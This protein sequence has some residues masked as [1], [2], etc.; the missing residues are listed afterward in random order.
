MALGVLS[1]I[2]TYFGPGL[3]PLR[4]ARAPYLKIWLK[5]WSEL[6]RLG[7]SRLSSLP[8]SSRRPEGIWP[9]LYGE[10][11]I[12]VNRQ[13]KV[14]RLARKT[15]HQDGS[16]FDR[17]VLARHTMDDPGLAKEIVKLFLGQLARLESQDWQ[18]FD[19]NFEM[20]TLR[21]SAAVVG[22]VRLRDLATVWQ[23]LGVEL[24][25]SIRSAIIEFRGIALG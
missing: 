19:L 24:E 11:C 14:E 9:G 2:L 25:P 6:N 12:S 17:D 18:E 23:D 13:L 20:H 16:I 4:A 21:G 10:N 3:N 8:V 15:A 5:S 22:A 1:R 7:K